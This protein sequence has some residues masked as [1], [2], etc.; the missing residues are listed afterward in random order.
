[1]PRAR[2]PNRDKAYEIWKENEGN[3]LLKDI[4]SELGVSD[5][6]VRKWKSQDKWEQ[7]MNG[8][9]TNSKRNVTNSKRNVTNQ[10]A[11]MNSKQNNENDA[12]VESDE[13]TDKQRLFCMYYTKYWNAGKAAKKAGY[14][15]SYPNGFYEIGSQ[16]LKKTQVKNKI[17]ELKRSIAENTSLES[18]AILQKYIDIAFADITDFVEFGQEKRPELDHNLEPMIDENGDEITYSFSYVN[19]K[20]HDEV[21]GTLIT[22]VKKGKDGVSIKLADK[23]KALDFLSK[24]TDL[25]SEN[26]KKRLQQEKLKTEIAKAQAE[27]DNMNDNDEDDSINIVISRKG[28]RD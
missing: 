1:M 14:D 2:D 25:L 5:T 6:Q 28:A 7:K 12:I 20:N 21:D 11:M 8:N 15:C 16:L 22:E 4:A 9:V 27:I 13:L 23:M 10:K 24:Y 3:K 18:K 19:F 17:D 26:D